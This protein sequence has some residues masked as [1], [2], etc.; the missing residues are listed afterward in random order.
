MMTNSFGNRNFMQSM[1]RLSTHSKCLDFFVLKFFEGGAVWER[2][3]FI[4]PLFLT[5]SFQVPIR[6]PMCF[7]RVFPIAPHFSPICFA[8]SPPLLTC[9][10]GPKG[11]ALHLSIESSILG[12]LHSFIFSGGGPEGS[13]RNLN[14]QGVTWHHF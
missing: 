9:I 8:Q 4:F 5:C 1:G 7:S 6:F 12:G 13:K 10:A 2:I 14:F 3:F 11:E